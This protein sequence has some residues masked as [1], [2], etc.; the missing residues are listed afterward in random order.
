MATLYTLSPP[1]NNFHFNW[2]VFFFLHQGACR[3]HDWWKLWRNRGSSLGHDRLPWS[4]EG[5][6]F[7]LEAILWSIGLVFCLR[8]NIQSVLGQVL[9]VS[10]S[11]LISLIQ[12]SQDLLK[13]LTSMPPVFPYMMYSALL[14]LYRTLVTSMAPSLVARGEP[15]IYLMMWILPYT[16]Y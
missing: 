12:E 9:K 15:N 13:C 16:V 11:I 3:S 2:L 1:L 8:P 14:Y 10:T 5:V 4:S 6:Y 7:S